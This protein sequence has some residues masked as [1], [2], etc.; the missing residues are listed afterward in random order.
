MVQVMH[1]YYDKWSLSLSLSLFLSFSL[2][3][4]LYIYIYIKCYRW[5]PCLYFMWSTQM[6]EERSR[7]GGYIMVGE[8]FTGKMYMHV[9]QKKKKR[10]AN[11][12][13]F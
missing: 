5:V 10:T 8:F 12:Y 4:S 9:M 1:T 2:S 7:K 6:S 11:I 3:L 13:I